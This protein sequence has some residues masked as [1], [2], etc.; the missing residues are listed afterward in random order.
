MFVDI[1]AGTPQDTGKDDFISVTA[2]A[3]LVAYAENAD[4]TA[5]VDVI[6]QVPGGVADIKSTPIIVTDPRTGQKDLFAAMGRDETN[7][8]TLEDGRVFGWNAQTGVLLPGWTQGQSTGISVNG[9]SGVYGALTSGQLEGNGLPDIVV[10]SFSTNVTAFRL[11]GSTLWQWTDDDTIL[12]GAAIGDIDRDGQNE[13]VVG[14]DSSPSSFYQAGGWVNVLSNTGILK[15]RKA[16]PGEVTWASPVLADLQNN[17]NLDIIIGT[18]LYYQTVNLSNG[19]YPAAQ[20]LGDRIYALDP[21]GNILPGWPYATTSVTNTVP[22]EVLAAPA[23]A[24][25]LG[26]GQLDVVAVDRAGFV[27]VISPTGQDLPRLRGRQAGRARTGPEQLFRRL[28]LADHRRHQWRRQT[29][30]H[31]EYRAILPGLRHERQP[32]P[33][34]HHHQPSRQHARRDR[35]GGGRRQLRRDG[36]AHAGLRL[37]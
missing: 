32:D 8:G 1:N 37:L 26:N 35:R 27:H 18:G 28:Q 29:R 3:R 5:R 25:L 19:Q 21:F 4:G 11:D 22:H 20:V 9:Q 2:G 34:R 6:Y 12:S 14:G 36:R 31:R 33:D 13:V 7:P 16:I 30:H 23:V 10:T 15:W 24:D 17:G